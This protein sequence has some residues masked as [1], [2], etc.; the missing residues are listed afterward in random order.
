MKNF[1]LYLITVV[2]VALIFASCKKENNEISKAGIVPLKTGNSWTYKVYRSNIVVDTII[3]KVGEYITLNGY[4]G[5]RYISGDNSFSETFLVD[6]DDN[7]NFISLGGYSDKDTL[8]ETS[9]RYKKGALKGDSWD[10]KEIS[11]VDHSY[12]EKVDI[13]MYCI[14]SDTTINTSKGD[15][16][17]KAYQWSPDKDADVFIDYMSENVGMVKS[18]HFENNK[19]FSYNVLIDYKIEK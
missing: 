10:F 14:N 9:I 1:K 18:E 4:N 15:F 17:C 3:L 11:Y 5:F 16:K 6:N 8:L 2:T 13:Q 19:L 12:F 7:G